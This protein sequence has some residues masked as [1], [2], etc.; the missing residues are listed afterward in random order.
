M[1]KKSPLS[2]AE[3]INSSPEV[4]PSR[5]ED[6][7][8]MGQ[9]VGIIAQ[10]RAEVLQLKRQIA[11]Q[12]APAALGGQLL[13]GQQPV[14]QTAVVGTLAPMLD[15]KIVVPKFRGGSTE[16]FVDFWTDFN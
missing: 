14:Q 10:L 16:E 12:Q 13:G 2:F 3:L 9:V 1:A 11:A 8:A 6:N 7:D 5:N 4:M 15:A